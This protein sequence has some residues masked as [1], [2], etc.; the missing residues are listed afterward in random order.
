MGKYS[1]AI[2]CY[3]R[4]IAIDPNYSEAIR[5]RENAFLRL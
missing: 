5:N 1:D 4:A 2:V 3:D